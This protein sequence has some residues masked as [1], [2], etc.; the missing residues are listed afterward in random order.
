MSCAP[1]GQPKVAQGNA[2]GFGSEDQ[3]HGDGWPG[4]RGVVGTPKERNDKISP[5]LNRSEWHR[6]R[7]GGG[8]RPRR[9]P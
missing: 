1:K 4:F 3:G 7:E 9:G 5:A 2:L 6:S 8:V